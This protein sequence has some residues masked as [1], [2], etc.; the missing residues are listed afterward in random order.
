MKAYPEDFS[1]IVEIP[2]TDL[3]GDPLTDILDITG[4][5]HDAEDRIVEDAIPVPFMSG[6][7]QVELTIHGSLNRL[8]PREVKSARVLRVA[9]ETT[10][11]TI[12]KSFSYL[13]VGDVRLEM[14]VNSFMS[15]EMV[16]LMVGDM[17]SLSGWTS[18]PTEQR[19]SALV[20]AYNKVTRIPLRFFERDED[21]RQLRTAD[22][23]ILPHMWSAIT[24]AKF[25]TYPDDFKSALRR[26]QITEANELLQGDGLMRRHRGGVVSETIGES[27]VTLKPGSVIDYGMSSQ[28]MNCLRGFVYSVV[29]I[30]RA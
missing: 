20:E 29:K 3:N 24:P 17:T 28:T 11:G 18:A 13:I 26:A 2:L 4:T 19:I 30:A 7:S 15:E 21:G 23:I 10:Q 8:D 12:R 16:D 25:L 27:S 22:H 6:D 5:L 14:M 1:V 9:I